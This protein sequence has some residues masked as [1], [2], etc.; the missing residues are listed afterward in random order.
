MRTTTLIAIFL[1][2][3]FLGFL[4]NSWAGGI[5]TPTPEPGCRLNGNLV[6]DDPPL[7]EGTKGDDY[8][9][10]RTSDKSHNIYGY[11]GNDVIFGGGG[12]SPA[13]GVDCD[14]QLAAAGSSL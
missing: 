2:L 14:L 3:F 7:I 11:G 1:S 9:D 4:T 8:I 13:S 5:P 6:P 12:S 10:C